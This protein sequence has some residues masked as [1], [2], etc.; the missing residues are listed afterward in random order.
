MR[1]PV[2]RMDILS[3]EEIDAIVESSALAR[4]YNR[5]V[6][7]ESAYEMLSSRIN[8]PARADEDA[9][10]T[11]FDTPVSKGRSAKEAP[12]MFEQVMKSPV[13]KILVREAARGLFGVLGLKSTTRRRRY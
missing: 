8:R 10:P 7:R 11:D 5:S 4:E 1:P 13:T 2:S 12:S 3:P 9:G 6:D